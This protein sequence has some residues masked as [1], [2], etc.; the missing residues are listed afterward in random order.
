MD[1]LQ[2]EKYQK[3]SRDFYLQDTLLTAKSLLGK[4]LTRT[5]GE[6]VTAGKIVETEAYLGPKD[7][8]AH[9]YKANPFGRTNVMYGPG[10]FAYIYLIYG[11]HYCMNV[12]TAPENTPEAI[13]IRALEPVAGIEIMAAR[14]GTD[15]I[16]SLCSGP[17]KLCKA[18]EIDKSLYGADLCGDTLSIT[19]GES[20]DPADIAVTPRIG[21]DYAGE[22]KDFP[23]RFLLRES[24]HVSVKYKAP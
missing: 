1:N 11:M 4:Y 18:L 20:V 16:T 13:L 8:A 15:K 3:L 17:G 5:D 2:D 6:A 23:F 14:R 9:S 19:Q 24:P 22:A 21:V 7:K 10:G 12:V